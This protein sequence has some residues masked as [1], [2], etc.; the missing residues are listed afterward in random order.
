MSFEV[1]KPGLLSAIQDEGR[2]GYRKHGVIVSGPMDHFA[3]RAA[4]LLVGNGS[5]AAT[6]EMTLQGPILIAQSD[7]LVAI[8]GADMGAKVDGD[9][10]PM[11]QPFVLHAGSELS[12]GYAVEGCRS[13]L[14]AHGGFKSDYILGSRSTY[15]RAAIGGYEG[16]TLRIGDVL[17]VEKGGLASDVVNE[18]E[19]QSK[20]VSSKIRPDYHDNPTIRIVRGREASIFTPN[21]WSR[22]LSQSFFVTSQS[23]RMGYRLASESKLELEAGLSYEMI[24]EAVVAG[25][26]QVPSSGQPI[27][28]MADCQTTGGYPRIGHVI[29]ADLPLVAQVKPGGQLRFQEVTHLEAQEQLLLQAM[30]LNLLGAGVRAWLRGLG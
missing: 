15:Q 23:D 19:L 9:S 18:V 7:M 27:L 29:T 6:L 24:S 3:H 11:W 16:R 12:V 17:E 1:I 8:C 25:T 20:F 2:Y 30:D 21:S 26:I 10:A 13:Y 14:A 4:N 28:L 22:L 5:E